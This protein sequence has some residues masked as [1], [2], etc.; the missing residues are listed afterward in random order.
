MAEGGNGGGA[1]ADGQAQGEGQGQ[2]QPQRTWADFARSLIFQMVIF[3]FISSYFR[4]NKTPPPE[5]TDE[6][7]KPIPMA[8]INLFT[9][10]QELVG[11]IAPPTRCG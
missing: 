8:G 10:G 1:V 9:K 4:G 11:A 5:S 7:G 2:G 6:D 3:Y